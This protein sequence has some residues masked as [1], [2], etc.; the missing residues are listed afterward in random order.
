M[1]EEYHR[2]MVFSI[3]RFIMRLPKSQLKAIRKKNR[4]KYS[5]REWF[6]G[7]VHD[8]VSSCAGP[9][10][11]CDIRTQMWL[12]CDRLMIILWPVAICHKFRLCTGFTAVRP[13]GRP[14]RYRMQAMKKCAEDMTAKLIIS[15]HCQDFWSGQNRGRLFCLYHPACDKAIAT[16][17]R[18]RKG[19]WSGNRYLVPCAHRTPWATIRRHVGHGRWAWR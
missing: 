6:K 14:L 17:F 5:S 15:V 1:T 12:R 13:L 4:G 2:S 3:H 16:E 18:R 11:F 9:F 19:C 7:P 10:F 8:G